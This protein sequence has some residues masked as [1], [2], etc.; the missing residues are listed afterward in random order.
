[1]AQVLGVN[2][3]EGVSRLVML[4]RGSLVTVRAARLLR[5]RWLIRLGS[6]IDCNNSEYID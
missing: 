3:I 5:D 1:M 2:S 6:P 4:W